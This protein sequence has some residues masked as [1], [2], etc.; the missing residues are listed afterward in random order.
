MRVVF[1]GTPDFAAKSL[2]KL[3]ESKHQVIAVVTQPDKPKGRGKKL[4]PPPVK[5]LA[6]K[7]GIP[8]LQPEKVKNNSELYET[9]KKLN[10]DIFVVV[11]YGKILP[12]KIIN[13]P[14]YRTIN[15]H[16]SLLPEYRGAAPIHRAIMEGKDKT[17]V[18]IMEITKELDAGDIYKC[19]EIP[20]T[21]KD[22]IVSLHDK[23]A[24][25]GAEL[26]LEVLDE[27]EKGKIIKKPQEHTKATYAKPIT[28]EEGKI[29]WNKSARE[30][31]NQIRALK[32]WP[33][34]FTNFR[35]KEIKILDSEVIDENSKGNAGKIVDIIKGKGFVVQ[36]GKGKIL[37]K[38]VQFP[39]SKPI[40][41]DEAVRGYHI[42]VGE[43]FE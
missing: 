6:E 38:K 30:I 33:K 39:N 2:E 34:A 14:K 20:I 16:A 24:K 15:V 40:S 9:L 5:V 7:H 36:T 4:T 31:F 37:I 28:K 12:E 42:E 35:D 43:R 23:L 26:L 19:V 22:D 11:A 10:P 3:I 17:G 25:A 1:W 27:I 8:V 21:E 18:C 41:A 13:L 32:V 29:N